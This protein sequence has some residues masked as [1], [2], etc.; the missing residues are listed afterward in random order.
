MD[1]SGSFDTAEFM[2]VF[3]QG[4]PGFV[5]AS[6]RSADLDHSGKPDRAEHVRLMPAPQH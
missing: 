4:A 1:G 6:M 3:G 2:H 5:R